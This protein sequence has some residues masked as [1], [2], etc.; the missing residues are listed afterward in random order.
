MWFIA[1]LIKIFIIYHHLTLSSIIFWYFSSTYNT[2]VLFLK[3]W[4]THV[5]FC[6]NVPVWV[7]YTCLSICALMH[8]HGGQKRAL[9]VLFNPCLPFPLRQGIF[10]NRGLLFIWLGW[11]PAVLVF[12]WCL[13]SLGFNLQLLAALLACFMSDGSEFWFLWLNIKF[14]QQLSIFIASTN[15]I[16]TTVLNSLLGTNDVIPSFK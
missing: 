9:E 15:F 12:L 8:V 2:K 1:R 10:L 4:C 16:W 13:P 5:Y 14:S 3:D 11:K 7:Y 6:L